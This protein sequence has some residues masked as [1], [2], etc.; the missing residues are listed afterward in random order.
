M[1]VAR[2]SPSRRN[3]AV[4]GS[5][6]T[7][8]S[9]SI[10]LKKHLDFDRFCPDLPSEESGLSTGQGDGFLVGNDGWRTQRAD[11]LDI[12]SHDVIGWY[13]VPTRWHPS[14]NPFAGSVPL[15][16]YRFLP[17]VRLSL[18]HFQKLNALPRRVYQPHLERRSSANLGLAPMAKNVSHQAESHTDTLRRTATATGGGWLGR[19]R[20]LPSPAQIRE[21]AE[22]GAT[23]DPAAWIRASSPK[24]ASSSTPS[25]RSAFS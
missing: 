22:A 14:R 7:R 8:A 19:H 23:G 16:D 2:G 11:C 25:N 1:A 10:L 13:G 20:G 6:F 24:P 3:S 5:T 12:D 9:S 4:N 17:V 21:V 15:Y 18:A